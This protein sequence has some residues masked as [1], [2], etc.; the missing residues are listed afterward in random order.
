MRGVLGRP[1]DSDDVVAAT[2]A[3]SLAWA[4]EAAARILY[5]FMK[6]EYFKEAGYDRENWEAFSPAK[7]RRIMNK[8]I[9]LAKEDE[10]EFGRLMTNIRD[11]WE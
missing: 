4:T 3:D 11:W 2:P 9:A 10:K 1:P 8:S 6:D 5:R 7:R